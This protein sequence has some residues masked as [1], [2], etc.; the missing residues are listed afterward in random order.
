MLDDKDETR[1]ANCENNHPLA[2]IRGGDGLSNVGP[3]LANLKKGGKRK[4]RRSTAAP[5]H[6]QNP[7]RSA[8]LSD[9]NHPPSSDPKAAAQPGSHPFIRTQGV[10]MTRHLLK[11]E[12]KKELPKSKCGRL[13]RG[14]VQPVGPAVRALL[15]H[16]Q[17]N[18]GYH[19]SVRRH[20]PG[21]P[22]P[23]RNGRS[24]PNKPQAHPQQNNVKKAPPADAMAEHLKDGEK[25]YAGA[26]FSEP[27][28]PSVLPKPP[29]H[30]VGE[31]GLQRR[32]QSREL[33]TVHLKSLLKVQDQ[34]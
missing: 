23:K 24:G 2:V 15:K 28:S 26:K 3:R 6:H 33:M 9:N 31:D 11:Q 7:A 34:V 27:P 17:I 32:N 8:H 13:E 5:L 1:I 10:I 16:E 4:Q 25:V 30:W 22:P 20:N 14:P 29:S 19:G 12:T 21:Q 18:A